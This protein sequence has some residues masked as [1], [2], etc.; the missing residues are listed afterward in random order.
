MAKRIFTR[1]IIILS[2]VSL[3][4]DISSE[5]LYPVLPLFLKEI[6]F[7]VLAIGILEGL[8]DAIAGFGKGYFGNLS[9]SLNRRNLFV[10][11]GY[12]LSCLAKPLMGLFPTATVVFPARTLDRFG[13]GLRTSPRDALLID[14]SEPQNRGKV[15]GFHRA[16]DTLGAV[17][18]P[19][20]AIYLLEQI[21]GDYTRLFL[22]AF[23]PGIIAFFFTLY[24]PAEKPV[25]NKN[26]EFSP[27][28]IFKFF[29]FWKESNAHY[30]KLVIGFIFFALFNSSDLFLLLRAK[31]FGMPDL[32]IIGAYVLYNIVYAIMSYPMGNLA[33]R[34]G[35]KTIYISG[36]LLF[37]VIY[38]IFGLG[39]P[40][41]GVWIL[42]G[43]YGLFSATNESITKAWISLYL[44][45]DKK[46]TG[47]G[48]Y[49]TLSTLAFTIASPL[50]GLLWEF[51][52]A[53]TAF[54]V[55]A[56]SALL[57]AL[58]FYFVKTEKTY[59][60]SANFS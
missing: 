53:Q 29:S 50:T 1:T 26:R 57:T 10:R 44:P 4:T 60:N 35:L 6:G 39:I 28:H 36:L 52:G 49:H 17:F 41:Y 45:T 14:E 2:L 40:S 33:D 59:S 25:K 42:L 16:M 46:G 24:L 34:I 47:M 32:T 55:I 5:M 20:L 19:L 48:L 18:G 22:L 23:I 30:K 54:T 51:A 43:F 11:T 58:Y 27:L 31:D 21:P 3:F 13:K 9:D 38:M 7:S 37:S 12:L 8:A 56:I 15:F